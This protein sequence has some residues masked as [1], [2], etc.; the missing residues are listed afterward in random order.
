MMDVYWLEQTEADL[1]LEND[2]LSAGEL[3]RLSGMRSAKRYADWRLGRWTAKR[4]LAIYLRLPS[5][6]QALVDIEVRPA[7]SGAPEVFLANKPSAITI[8][9][10]HRAAVAA[11]AIAQPGTDLG[12]DLEI[13]EPRSDAFITDYFAS[14]EQVL[15]QGTSTADRARLL[16]ML[17]SGKESALKALRTGLR[18]DTRSVV[19]NPGHSPQNGEEAGHPEDPSFFSGADDVNNWHPLHVVY[20]GGKIFRGWW[21]NTGDLMR[22]MVASP[23]PAQPIFLEVP[24]HSAHGGS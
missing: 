19:V 10:S 17:W 3:S 2:W 11:C 4:A 7:A 13:I 6:P 8:S 23:A 16:A 21:Q 22:T 9:L 5:H 20:E 24:T 15:I 18:V 12:C 14:G 1:P